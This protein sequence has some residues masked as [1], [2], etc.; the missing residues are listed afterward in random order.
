MS[1]SLLIFRAYTTRIF[2]FFFIFL[3]VENFELS[4][5]KTPSK[6]Y[7]FIFG[8]T[9]DKRKPSSNMIKEFWSFQHLIL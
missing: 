5:I 4:Q 9:S 7:D 6:K 1:M 3:I 8:S 2:Y